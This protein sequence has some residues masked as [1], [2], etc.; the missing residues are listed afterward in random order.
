MQRE[1]EAVV[2]SLK[3]DL[4]KERKQKEGYEAKV[5]EVE[6]RLAKKEEDYRVE[7]E[8]KEEGMRREVEERLAKQEEGYEAEMARLQETVTAI[9]RSAHM[10]LEQP[11]MPMVSENSRSSLPKTVS[12]AG[13]TTWFQTR[14]QAWRSWAETYAHASP[15][16]IKELHPVQ[17]DELCKGVAQFVRLDD[18]GKKLPAQFLTP[19]SSTTTTMAMGATNRNVQTLLCAI[20]GN[21]ATSSCLQD[22]FWIFKALDKQAI[23]EAELESPTDECP[24]EAAQVAGFTVNVDHPVMSANLGAS[25]WQAW[26]F[27]PSGEPVFSPQAALQNMP[28]VTARSMTFMSPRHAPPTF[29]SMGSLAFVAAS[30]TAGLKG[31]K[32]EKINEKYELPTWEQVMG[33][34]GFV[35]DLQPAM[36]ASFRTNLLSLLS[37]SGDSHILQQLDAARR[38]YARKLKDQFLSGP[39]RFLLADQSFECIEQ[40]EAAL[41]QELDACLKFSTQLWAKG[42]LSFKGLGDLKREDINIDGVRR[43]SEVAMVLQPAIT[44]TSSVPASGMPR[45]LTKASV[46]LSPSPTPSPGLPASL[47]PHSARSN[48]SPRSAMHNRTHAHIRSVSTANHSAHTTFQSAPFASSAPSAPSASLS[49]VYTYNHDLNSPPP[50]PTHTS[51]PGSPWYDLGDDAGNDRFLIWWMAGNTHVAAVAT[52]GRRTGNVAGCGVQGFIVIAE[53]IEGGVETAGD[54]AWGVDVGFVVV[55][56]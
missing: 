16:R 49:H 55:V 48:L 35:G 42:D 56:V 45:T 30:K 17:M 29:A 10:G 32:M 27:S 7:M 31:G 44:I 2:W 24:S 5:K 28:P 21:F 1:H 52:S 54:G 18:G 37:Q 22:P 6:E 34:C 13:V 40:L 9:N 43:N 23:R 39:A 38:K 46:L 4:V 51:A 47:S 41:E 20:L 19:S 53:E 14:S 33:L 15:S 8:K 11:A 26:Q 50:A 25:P 36:A 12:D 3:D